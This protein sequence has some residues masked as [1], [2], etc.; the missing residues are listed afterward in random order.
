MNLFMWLSQAGL[1]AELLGE[2]LIPIGTV[3]D[4]FICRGLDALIY[5]L[6]VGSQFILVGTPSGVTLAPEGGAHQSTVTPSLGVELPGLHS[7]EPAFAHEVPWILEDAIRAVRDRAGHSTY[8]RLSTRLVDQGLAARIRER[9]DSASLRRDVLAGGYRLIE[10]SDDPALPPG[11]PVVNVVAMGAVVTEAAQAV[12]SLLYEEVAANLIVVTSADRL[13]TELHE[14]RL[15]SA[16]QATPDRLPHAA[17]LFPAKDRR[18][19]MV[20]VVDGA[21]HALSFLGAAFGAPVVPLGV[22]AFGQTG[23]IGD[24]YSYA[25]IDA[26]HIMDAALLALEL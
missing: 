20:T 7:F 14:Q 3:Y 21:S 24:L 18:A 4:P 5:A 2:A 6:Y 23:R 9:P 10:S 22:D 13:S 15:A 19:P 1:S 16:R 12:Q 17:T 25:G 26:A 11:S 8:L